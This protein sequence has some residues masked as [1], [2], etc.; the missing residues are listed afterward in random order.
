[1]RYDS[2]HAPIALQLY[3]VRDRLSADFE[4]TIRTI[5]SYGYRAVETA[6]VYGESPARA[7]VLFKELGIQ[8]VSLHAAVDPDDASK[9][10]QVVE[11]AAAFGAKTIVHP[12]YPAEHFTTLDGVERICEQLNRS[13]AQL[14]AAGLTLAYHN[15]HFECL[16][17]PDGRLPLLHMKERLD[18]AI[19]FEVDT[20]W[21]QTAGV[22]VIALLDALGD[23]TALLHIKDGSTELDQ[24]MV[25]VGDGVMNFPAILAG[26][27]VSALI[28]ELDRCATDMLA[29]VEKSYRYVSQLVGR[30]GMGD[31]A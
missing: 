17:L 23:R 16:S 29:A 30:L 19:L 4:G 15:H 9:L 25:A 6:G 3:S 10:A 21:V 8:V 7:A 28:V 5:A 27:Q 11:S 2:M 22:N 1:M 24:P 13:H 31:G 18:P 20:Y 26:R 12:W 14:A